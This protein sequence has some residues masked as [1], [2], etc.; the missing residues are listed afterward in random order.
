LTNLL[1]YRTPKRFEAAFQAQ[2]ATDN[3]KQV[4][5][6]SALFL[7]MALAFRT[8][9]IIFRS[10]ELLVNY[11]AYSNIN[12]VQMG[13]TFLLLVSSSLLLK[14][15]PHHYKLKRIVTLLFVLFVLCITLS[16]SYTFS[17]HNTKNN[18]MMFLV[19]IVTV[20]LFFS[21]ELVEIVGASVFIVLLYSTLIIRAGI[22]IND[23]IMN[24]F[25]GFILGFILYSFSRY[26][27]YFKSQ[28]F[29]RL[30]QLEEKNQEIERLLIQQGEILGFVAHDLRNPLNNI[31]ALSGMLY[32]ENPNEEL[33]HI[34][35]ATDKAKSMINDLIVAIKTDTVELDKQAENLNS[36]LEAVVQKWKSNSARNVTLQIAEEAV[37]A[38]INAYKMERVLDNLISNALK[39]S[40]TDQEVAV[41][42]TTRPENI[43]IQVADQGIG[44]PENL[45]PFIFQQFSQAGRTGLNGEKS[46]GLGLHISKKIMHQHGGDLLVRSKENQGTVFTISLPL[47]I[48]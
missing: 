47:V 20:S 40:A 5:L 21:L 31:E 6:L 23:Q 14:Y 39:F 45:I 25:A 15:A 22:S 34:M 35:V 9:Y 32:E 33:R 42:L 16:V 11:T 7:L 3:I 18:L 48:S 2:Y 28:H 26:S 8:C 12:W 17:L 13:G 43:L 19:G 29:V 1:N 27:Y 4:R 10:D 44:I 41:S 24:I 30:K 46:L 38:P 36:F 37:Y